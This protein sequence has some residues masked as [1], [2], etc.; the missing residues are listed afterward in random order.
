MLSGTYATGPA[1]VWHFFQFL[2]WRRPAILPVAIVS[3]SSGRA[4]W[5]RST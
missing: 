4:A 2:S 3:L 1:L 5:R